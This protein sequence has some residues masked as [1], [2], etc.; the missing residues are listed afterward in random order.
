MEQTNAALYRHHGPP[1]GGVS[2]VSGVFP[3]MHHFLSN[4]IVKKKAEICT[5]IFHFCPNVV[6]MTKLMCLPCVRF[7][8]CFQPAQIF[9]PPSWT[10]PPGS[11][12]DALV[13]DAK[14]EGLNIRRGPPPG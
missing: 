14:A 13:N 9:Q 7:R 2:F 1:T 6:K 11:Q 12:S 5:V 4:S 10:P 3:K 8:P